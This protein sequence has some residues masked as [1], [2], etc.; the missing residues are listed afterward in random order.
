MKKLVGLHTRPRDHDVEVAVTA[1]V[2]LMQ[3]T[4]LQPNSL[5]RRLS[6]RIR[7][8]DNESTVH[9]VRDHDIAVSTDPR[10]PA[11]HELAAVP[12]RSHSIPHLLSDE[13]NERMNKKIDRLVAA[14]DD[15]RPIHFATQTTTGE[16]EIFADHPHE[17]ID[18]ESDKADLERDVA[19]SPG[20]FWRKIRASNSVRRTNSLNSLQYANSTASWA[21]TDSEKSSS[22]A[23]ERAEAAANDRFALAC[24]GL[25]HVATV[26]RRPFH[27]PDRQA[28]VQR[29]WRLMRTISPIH[30]DYHNRTRIPTPSIHSNGSE[31]DTSSPSFG[32]S[33]QRLLEETY[34]EP[35]RY[36]FQREYLED[37]L[38]DEWAFVS[39]PRDVPLPKA[40]KVETPRST[41]KAFD[42]FRDKS[43]GGALQKKT[44]HK[45][46]RSEALKDVSNLRRP[47][48]LKF[49]SFAK[50]ADSAGD[51]K[52]NAALGTAASVRLDSTFNSISRRAYVNKK[53]PGLLG[54][55]SSGSMAEPPKLDGA[56]RRRNE[57]ATGRPTN[58]S[59]YSLSHTRTSVEDSRLNIN[60]SRQAHFDLALAR[61]EGRALP[62]PPSPISRYPDWA[63]LYD[64]DVYIE[65]GHRP[66]PLH[67]PA[68][69]RRSEKRPRWVPGR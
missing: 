16:V 57:Q 61:L 54:D 29:G 40:P 60:P 3:R 49:N 9:G 1:G 41:A 30:L 18:R 48:Y 50:D 68:P 12:D 69:G 56:A 65:G 34:A 13:E 37:S 14:I 10:L 25:D 33:C 20:N 59:L 28:P 19:A 58:E 38:P 5:M 51:Q 21:T 4:M 36:S 35:P 22:K 52:T 15:R 39:E 11:D 42:V 66:L 23:W 8:K 47:G 55:R 53:W 45:D 62:P 17:V 2:G 64:R 44:G 31:Q 46:L 63:A 32:K 6:R 26:I 67:E 43:N 7:S 24:S 27:N